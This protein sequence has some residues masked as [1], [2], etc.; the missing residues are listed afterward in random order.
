MDRTMRQRA[1]YTQYPASPTTYYDN[2]LSAANRGTEYWNNVIA[3]VDPLIENQII[4]RITQT[5]PLDQA[6]I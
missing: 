6:T 1:A 5:V 2:A 4:S 3:Y